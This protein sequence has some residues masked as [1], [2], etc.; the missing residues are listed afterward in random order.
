MAAEAERR[1]A[2]GLL[3]VTTDGALPPA[4]AACAPIALRLHLPSPEVE[5]NA[6]ALLTALFPGRAVLL[7]RT[8]IR[9]R[10]FLDLL[11][12]HDFRIRARVPPELEFLLPAAARPFDPR[13]PLERPCCAWLHARGALDPELCAAI[14]DTAQ[15]LPTALVPLAP[16]PAAEAPGETRFFVEARVTQAFARAQT[17]ALLDFFPSIGAWLGV[18][19]H[20]GDGAN[21]AWEDPAPDRA[22]FGEDW[23]RG[24]VRIARAGDTLVCGVARHRAPPFVRTL[25]WLLGRW[26]TPSSRTI[27]DARARIEGAGRARLTPLAVRARKE[28][29]PALAALLEAHV[30]RY[31]RTGDEEVM[32]R[33]KDLGYL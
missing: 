2:R 24:L 33:L 3:L 28:R 8:E 11:A 15:E 13:A 5:A 20:L 17:A 31:A 25:L 16:R 14:A 12:R 10:T 1:L 23:R 18:P 27:W 30:R 4:L 22:F 9:T 32:G 6:A 21:L 19:L 29:V 7:G 26:R